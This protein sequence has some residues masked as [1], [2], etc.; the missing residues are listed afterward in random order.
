[1]EIWS[2]GRGEGGSSDNSSNDVIVVAAGQAEQAS[3]SD[4][5]VAPSRLRSARLRQRE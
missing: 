2:I 4:S 5:E 1:M 3:D